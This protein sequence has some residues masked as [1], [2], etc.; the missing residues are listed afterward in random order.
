MGRAMKFSRLKDDLIMDD[1][2]HGAGIQNTSSITCSDLGLKYFSWRICIGI[3]I[4]L[5]L[6]IFTCSNR[7]VQNRQSLDL[8]M[9]MNASMEKQQALRSE[10]QKVGEMLNVAKTSLKNLETDTNRLTSD[11]PW[12]G[13]IDKFRADLRDA[14]T[15]SKERIGAAE[16]KLT[17]AKKALKNIKLTMQNQSRELENMKTVNKNLGSKVDELTTNN[18]VISTIIHQRIDRISNA[19]SDMSI[20]HEELKDNLYE[21]IA[22]IEFAQEVMEEEAEQNLW[23]QESVNED[24]Q[25][26][27]L[28]LETALNMTVTHWAELK[29][30]HSEFANRTL[31]ILKSLVDLTSKTTTESNDEEI[32]S[33]DAYEDDTTENPKT[34]S[35][36]KKPVFQNCTDGRKLKPNEIT[37]KASSEFNKKFGCK[38][39]FDG[40]LSVGKKKSAWATKGE[41]IGSWIQATFNKTFAI[42]QLKILQRHFPAESNKK[43]ELQFSSG[44]KQMATLPAKG[45]KHWNIIRLSNGVL[46]DSVKITVK[47]VYGTINN[48]FK[49]IQIFG[50]S[51]RNKN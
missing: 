20:N 41:G 46:S 26:E 17:N 12:I 10:L 43:V 22:S 9:K 19:S 31:G 37:C 24:F 8:M 13:D 23:N 25:L 27:I 36:T 51:V 33:I 6:L 34:S 39:A 2:S 15:A 5:F 11:K 16:T 47:D 45:D 3:L 18:S 48:G 14:L 32:D 4:I 42:N 44:L 35:S 49:E 21:Q 38:K 29:S 50:C 7:V 40:N 30:G 1:N 28:K